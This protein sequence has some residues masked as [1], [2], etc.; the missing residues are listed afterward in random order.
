MARGTKET[1]IRY[2][3][4]LQTSVL[5]EGEKIHLATMLRALAERGALP[6]VSLTDKERIECAEGSWSKTVKNIEEKLKEKNHV[7]KI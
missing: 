5:Q 1:L 6:W 3:T 4:L 2:A 7:G